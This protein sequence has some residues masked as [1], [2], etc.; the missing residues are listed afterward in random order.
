M[1]CEMCEGILIHLLGAVCVILQVRGARS[2][3]PSVEV[4]VLLMRQVTGLK[5]KMC[6]TVTCTW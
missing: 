3:G 1:V 2:Q 6:Q 5:R 4:D